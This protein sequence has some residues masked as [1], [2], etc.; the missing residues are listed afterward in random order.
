MSATDFAFLAMDLDRRGWQ[1]ANRVMNRYVARTGDIALRGFPCS[2]PN[3]M[4][5]AHVLNAMNQDGAADLAA[6]LT[7]LDPAPSIVIAIGGLQGTGKST[8]ARTLAPELGPA[9]GALVLRS[10]EIRKRLHHAEP[11]ALPETPTAATEAANT[12]T[13]TPPW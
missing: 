1:A 11:E 6:A 7:Y 10:D 13:K 8:L 3:A 9:P 4:I 2:C 5:R 12:A